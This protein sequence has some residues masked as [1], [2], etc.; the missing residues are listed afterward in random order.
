[1]FANLLQRN[2]KPPAPNVA[3]CS[4]ITVISTWEGPLYLASVIDLYSRRLI[5]FAI[6]EHCKA[7]LVCDALKM[8]LATRRGHVAGSR[9]TPPD[10]GARSRS[11]NSW[12]QPRHSTG[13]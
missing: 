7:P 3:W 9:G 6:A 11:V 13:E 4:D 5:G 12:P 1:M 8:A 2:F 10:P